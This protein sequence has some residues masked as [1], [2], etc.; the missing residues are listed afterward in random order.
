M[1]NPDQSSPL[2]SPPPSFT[3]VWFHKEKPEKSARS[4]ELIR[5]NSDFLNLPDLPLA[6]RPNKFPPAPNITH[7]C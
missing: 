7:G 1:A 3:F 2:P 5:N 6:R 4:Q